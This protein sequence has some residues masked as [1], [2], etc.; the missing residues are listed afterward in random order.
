M[1]EAGKPPALPSVQALISRFTQDARFL[2]LTTPLGAN[3]LL[4]EC[5]RAEE[6]IS[7]GFTLNIAALSTDAAIPLKSLVGSP[8]LLELLVVGGTRPFHGRITSAELSGANAGFARYHLVV[9]PWT[10]FLGHTCD[11]R[12][13]Q[14]MTVFEILDAVFARYQG[15]GRLAPAWQFDVRDRALYPRRSHITQY[16]ESDLAFVQRLMLDEGLFHFFEHSGDAG[17]PGLGSHRLII[18]DHNG[19]FKPIAQRTVRFTQPGAVMKEDC[20]D[21]WRC[22]STLQTNAIELSSWD[23]R[24]RSMRRVSSSAIDGGRLALASRDTPGAYAY[25]TREQGNRIANNQMQALEAQQQ[26]FVGAGTVR[27]LAPGTSFRLA[28]HA[29]DSDEY[30]VLR[31]V[32]LMHNNLRADMRARVEQFL[33]RGVLDLAIAQEQPAGRTTIDSSPA[34]RPLY[35]NRIDA[36]RSSMP[37]RSTGTDLRGRLL[38]PRPTVRGQQT[39]IVVGPAGAMIHTD[40]DHRI[41]VQFH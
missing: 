16:Q 41:K 33:G 12:I 15:Q 28:E 29:T 4:A 22:E 17:S 23:Y 11:S 37:F 34:E 26:T 35:R 21:R 10:A 25:A 3:H 2:K 38:H 36:L 40:R 19:S 5:V 39:A 14:D 13:F 31:A 20:I 1:S 18:S 32:H 6:D 7:Q 9:Q 8:L 24:S 27:T 30:V